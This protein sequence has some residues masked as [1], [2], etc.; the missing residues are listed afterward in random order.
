M[1]DLKKVETQIIELAKK[2]GEYQL[3]KSCEIKELIG[4]TSSIDFATNVDVECEKIIIDYIKAHY[5]EHDILAEE[6]GAHKI[7]SPYKWIIDPIDGTSNYISAY[8]LYAVS[9]ALTYEDE[10]VLGVVYLPKLNYMYHGSKGNGSYLNDKKLEVSKVDKLEESIIATG[11]SYDRKREDN[12]ADEFTAVMPNV[13]GIR[14]SGTCAFDICCVAEGTLAGYW[15][16]ATGKWDYMA[17]K[18][19]LLEAGGTFISRPSTHEDRD[20]LFVTNGLI[21]DELKRLIKF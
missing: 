4:K 7:K 6:S 1:L 2:V 13:R 16:I 18:I 11:F 12:N 15:E 3:G 10:A 20:Y 17:G 14:R 8:P 21:D 19:I 9:I 5:P